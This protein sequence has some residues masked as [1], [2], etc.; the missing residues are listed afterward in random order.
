MQFSVI[1]RLLDRD[2]Y[3]FTGAKSSYY[4]ALVDR[5]DWNDRIAIFNEYKR[6]KEHSS[7]R[8]KNKKQ[9][10]KQIIFSNEILKK[11]AYEN[12]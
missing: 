1:P 12:V 2:G 5:V 6:I 7:K 9:T 3:S 4:T 8:R 10:K 11:I